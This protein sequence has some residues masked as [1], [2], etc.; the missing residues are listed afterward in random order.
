MIITVCI[1]GWSFVVVWDLQFANTMDTN[2]NTQYHKL[3]FLGLL[4]GKT[5]RKEWLVRECL[6][7]AVIY[8]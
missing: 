5:G 4:N 6:F 7:I 8:E 3:H 1:F 2:T